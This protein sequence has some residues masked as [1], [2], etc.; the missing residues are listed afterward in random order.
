MILLGPSG[1][2]YDDWIGTVYPA[3][4]PRREWLP[5]IAKQFGTIELNVTYYRVPEARTVK[6]WVSRTPDDFRF[7]VKAH[8]SLTHEREAPDFAGFLESLAPLR[9]SNKLACVLAQFPYSFHPQRESR[10]YLGKLAQGMGEVPVV[11]EFRDSAW[12]TEETFEGLRRL[13]LG[14]CCVDEPRLQGLMPPVVRATGTVGYVRYHG[15]NAER[16]W[17]HENAWERYDYSYKEEELR[18]WIPG[19]RELEADTEVTLVYANNHYRGQ[20]I[21]A[22]RTLISLLA[23]T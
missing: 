16:W 21:S 6:G 9:D 8:Q 2:S 5:F 17:E 22:L 12:V 10:D 14:F 19:L 20:S 15:R 7:S 1:F 18:E 4:L 11:I 13:G 23:E 3:D